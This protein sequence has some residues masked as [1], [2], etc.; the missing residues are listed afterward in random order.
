[1]NHLLHDL[2]YALR[3]F[4][5]R[6]A[7]TLTTL[8]V[9]AL[10]MA[11]AASLFSFVRGYTVQPPPGVPQADDLVR[12]RGAWSAPAGASRRFF[13]PEEFAA[14]AAASGVFRA[15]AGWQHL[16]VP[17][18][19]RRH[20]DPEWVDA[21]FVSDGY[22][23]VVG[24]P[25]AAGTP[26]AARPEAGPLVA[27][28][29]HALR[30]RH[31]DSDAAAIGAILTVAGQ[32]VTIVGVTAPRFQGVHGSDGEALWLPDAAQLRL[33][34]E[35]VPSY[36]TVAR[37][38]PGVSLD[39]ASA[40]MA[41]LAARAPLD[42]TAA[43]ER[44]TPVSRVLPLATMNAEP[45]FDREVR[46]LLTGLSLLATLVLLVT[47]TNASA[48]Q[49]GVAMTRGREIAMRHSLG[50]SRGRVLR[51]LLTES[52]LLGVLAGLAAFGLVFAL[53]AVLQAELPQMPFEI[54]LD[55]VAVGFT[56]AIGVVT[57]VFAGLSPALHATRAGLASALKS[58]SGG[59]SGRR[60][61]LL[62]G[63]VVAQVLL[64]QPLVV[65]LTAMLLLMVTDLQRTQLSTGAAQ[66]VTLRLRASG[67][68]GAGLDM[69]RE[70]ERLRQ[71]L[72]ALPGVQRAVRD[73]RETYWLSGFVPASATGGDAV[74]LQAQAVPEGWFETMGTALRSGRGFAPDDPVPGIGRGDLPVVIGEDLAAARWPGASPLGQR[75]QPDG[76]APGRHLVVV[77]VVA[78][79]PGKAR[80]PREA[81]A[82]YLPPPAAAEEVALRLRM[83]SDASASLDM[84]RAELRRAAPGLAVMELRTLAEVEAEERAAYLTGGMVFAGLGVVALLLAAVGLYA[85]VAFVVAQRGG[86]IAVR[87]AVGARS[88]QVV[89]RTMGEGLRLTA[90]GLVL[91]LPLSLAGLALVTGTT[92]LL[93]PVPV[94]QVGLIAVL[95]VASVAALATWLPARR[96]ARIAPADVLRVE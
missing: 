86:E 1:M 67:A 94:W 55:G 48:L 46:N 40:A 76:G 35:A 66:V 13:A 16:Q 49:T 54:P 32:A 45:D 14:Q 11:V 3:H 15:V 64:T 84:I 27:V 18:E 62:S 25:F 91:G 41:A 17:I 33:L 89:R 92:S 28:I 53:G 23:E 80:R 43:Q 44:R 52:G 4:A 38:A 47:G 77:G 96:V 75:L 69:L 24:V 12:V 7:L 83:R 30:T 95:G 6:P 74:D 72:A 51:Q 9:L 20:P 29:S 8:L 87:L 57:G 42:A 10:G 79:S 63:L 59:N 81:F 22:F 71:R 82:V 88:G 56:I 93:P 19:R 2:R 50:A 68:E 26:F 65:M 5:R 85:V 37:L 60:H 31:F 61:R 58:G 39:A 70:T 78:T 36:G 73:P 34:P 90:L 21:G